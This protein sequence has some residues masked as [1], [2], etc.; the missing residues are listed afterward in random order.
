MIF[1]LY[2]Q[3]LMAS[4]MHGSLQIEHVPKNPTEFIGTL[5]EMAYAMSE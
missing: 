4:G 1:I 5:R 3:R 2:V